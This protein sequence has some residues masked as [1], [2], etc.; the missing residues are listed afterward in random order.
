MGVS[1]GWSKFIATVING[2][3]GPATGGNASTTVV[4][5]ITQAQ[6]EGDT[7]VFDPKGQ[8]S[9]D[10]L[11]QVM[12][13][14]DR[15]QDGA[16][17]LGEIHQMQFANAKTAKGAAITKLEFG[18]LLSMFSDTTV[19]GKN[20]QA[21]PALSKAQLTKFYDGSLFQ[22]AL[23]TGNVKLNAGLFSRELVNAAGSAVKA[24][25]GWTPK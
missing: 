4:P 1:A 18:L 23:K 16:L 6:H 2:G 22:D 3:L 15:N 14:F 13:R 8:F 17:S 19:K 5:T 10:R 25:V 21:E 7:G 24:A 20:G 12:T 11:N 9:P